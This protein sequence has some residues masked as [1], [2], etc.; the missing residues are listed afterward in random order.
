MAR[1]SFTTILEGLSMME[2]IKMAIGMARAV[3]MVLVG[4]AMKANGKITSGM[5]RATCTR[6]MES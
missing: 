2:N 4:T 6:P 3:G 5:A 1:E